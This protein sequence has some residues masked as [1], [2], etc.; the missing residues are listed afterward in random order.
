MT[1][2]PDVIAVIASIAILG[3]TICISVRLE[4]RRMRRGA[5]KT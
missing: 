2:P 3:I 4:L 5:F 1:I